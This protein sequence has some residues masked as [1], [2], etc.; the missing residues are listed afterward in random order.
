[1]HLQSHKLHLHNIS[2]SIFS[3]LTFVLIDSGID[4]SIS[5]SPLKKI[6]KS[7][8]SPSSF[9]CS[10]WPFVR[11][12]SAW[13][14]RTIQEAI[15][16]QRVWHDRTIG[17]AL[18]INWWRMIQLR[19]YNRKAI[20]IFSG[21]QTLE[22]FEDDRTNDSTIDFESKALLGASI[23]RITIW[24]VG[25]YEVI[26]WHSCLLTDIAYLGYFKRDSKRWS[27]GSHGDSVMKNSIFLWWSFQIRTSCLES[28]PF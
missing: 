3:S 8:C 1:M 13:I 15:Y 25:T 11:F 27:N 22:T 6:F 24:T 28:A 14:F 4:W 21:Y 10:G 7:L 20:V 2:Y 18:T 9:H 26:S 16:Q 17:G 5:S 23:T 19:L 12:P